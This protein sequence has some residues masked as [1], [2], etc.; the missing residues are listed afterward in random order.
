MCS[1]W[2]YREEGGAGRKF[3]LLIYVLCNGTTLQSVTE[4]QYYLS[5]KAGISLSESN[6]LADFEREAFINLILKDI[7][8][9][10]ETENIKKSM[11]GGNIR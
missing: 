7:R 2:V 8:N 5:S 4:D 11:M 9:Q 3:F 6:M 1:L 10:T